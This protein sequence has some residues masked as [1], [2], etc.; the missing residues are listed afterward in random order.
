MNN[1]VSTDKNKLSIYQ[2]IQE[3]TVWFENFISENSKETYRYAITQF[4]KFLGIK[5]KEE[6]RNIKN[7]HVIRFR[8]SLLENGLSPSTVNNRLSAISSL[9]KHLIEQQIVKINPV[10]GVKRSRMNYDVVKSR[11]LKKQDVSDLFGLINKDTLKGIRDSAIMHILFYTGCRISE[12]AKLKV[13]DYY[14]DDGYKILDFIVKGGKQNSVALNTEAH[15][16]IDC[17]LEQA[18]HGEDYDA[19]LF[20]NVSRNPNHEKKAA[21]TRMALTKV[22][23]SYVKI[24]GFDRCWPHSA[25]ATFITQALESGTDIADVQATVAHTSIRTT[26]MYD[27]RLKLHKNSASFGVRY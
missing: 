14:E 16:V 18:E 27:Q 25:R 17:Y 23:R 21:L 15:R 12:I 19:P 24:L 10:I 11:R 7:I 4:I 22:W 6:L 2:N 26:K 20:Q 9:F 3:E 1:I 13:K 5:R 8:D